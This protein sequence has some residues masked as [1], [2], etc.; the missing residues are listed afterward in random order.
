[1]TA[2]V[3]TIS[4]GVADAIN[5]GS[6]SLAFTA[7]HG[8]LTKETL[9]DLADLKVIVTP[10]NPELTWLTEQAWDQ[11]YSVQVVIAKKVTAGEDSE[12]DDL[13]TVTDEIFNALRTYKSTTT[14]K[15]RVR[16]VAWSPLYDG[17]ILR[18]HGNF[19]AALEITTDYQQ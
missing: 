18:E 13:L 12:I 9:A 7:D 6:Y 16:E 1:M 10:R 2:P 15:W 3:V 17:K 4:K 5:A 19:L 8:Y 14:P 11:R